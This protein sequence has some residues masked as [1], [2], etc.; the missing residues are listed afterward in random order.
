M[1]RVLREGYDDDD[2]DDD[3]IRNRIWNLKQS[4]CM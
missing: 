1:F 4:M 3:K 2:D